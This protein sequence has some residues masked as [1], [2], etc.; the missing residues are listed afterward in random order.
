MFTEGLDVPLLGVVI[1]LRPTQ[2][3]TL[4]LQMLGRVTR[5]EPGT[6]RG[7]ILDHA[8]DSLRQGLYD[9]EHQWLLE[10]CPKKDREALVRR[11]PQ[12]GAMLPIR[13]TSCSECSFWF[14]VHMQPPRFPEATA[15]DLEQIDDRNL[16]D[17]EQLRHMPY[18]RL[19][20][21]C[22]ADDIR[23][24]LPRRARGYRQRW[25]F[26]AKQARLAAMASG[27]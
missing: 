24:E 19:L 17:A 7:L 13:A 9:F 27:Q 23:L 22:G 25:K 18:R 15:G 6:R 21:W 4:H 1:I 5:A 8:G 12:C 26:Q 16:L 14:V 3:L 10:G 11:R 2:S 20:D